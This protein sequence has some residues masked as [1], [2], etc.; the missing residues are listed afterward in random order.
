HTRATRDWSSD[1]CSSD[2]NSAGVEYAREPVE[3][4]QLRR[5]KLHR[6][7]DVGHALRVNQVAFGREGI[8][9][10]GQREVDDDSKSPW[11]SAFPLRSEERRVGRREAHS[12]RA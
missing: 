1:V 11:T 2:L 5:V 3:V 4:R 6:D 9:G 12:R 8:V 10:R 7:V